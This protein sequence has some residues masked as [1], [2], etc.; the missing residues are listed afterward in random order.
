MNQSL[1][2]TILYVSNDLDEGRLLTLAL[3]DERNDKVIVCDPAY[4]RPQNIVQ[5]E[6]PDLVLI[7]P[8]AVGDL[9]AFQL[10]QQLRAI[11]ALQQV[12][13]LFWRVA[14]NPE[15]FYLKARQLG[16]AGCLNYFAQVRDLLIARDTV[17]KGETYYS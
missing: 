7:K 12:P 1:G 4:Q 17:L 2:V 8:T 14:A 13:I 3:R 16:A 11:P 9:D 15:E 5:Q 6:P 10:Y